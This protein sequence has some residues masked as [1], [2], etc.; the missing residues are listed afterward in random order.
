MPVRAV[1]TARTVAKKGHE[2]QRKVVELPAEIKQRNAELNMLRIRQHWKSPWSNRWRSKLASDADVNVEDSR[3]F[4]DD[5]ALLSINAVAAAKSVSNF[6][7][8]RNNFKLQNSMIRQQWNEVKR[9][10]I[11]GHSGYLGIHIKRL[12]E[13]SGALQ[14]TENRVHAVLDDPPCW[15]E[16]DVSQYFLSKA[17]NVYFDDDYGV[18]WFGKIEI[19]R[20]NKR[21][22]NPICHPQSALLTMDNFPEADEWDEEWYTTWQSRKD[23]PNTLVESQRYEHNEKN[24]LMTVHDKAP[25][26]GQ[27]CSLRNPSMQRISR[28]HFKYTSDCKKSSWTRKY[29]PRRNVQDIALLDLEVLP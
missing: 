8:S 19:V 16:R 20:N 22:H 29:A 3:L 18:N 25:E 23:N 24:W 4:I 9:H 28:V 26:I 1:Q 15:D 21:T 14:Y 5:S 10:R 11:V 17:G 13:T 6:R 2:L 7:R 12:L 27:I